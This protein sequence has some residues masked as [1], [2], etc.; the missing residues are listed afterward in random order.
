MRVN[1]HIR[2]SDTSWLC[3]P[4]ELRKRVQDSRL[5]RGSGYYFS[6]WFVTSL[7][8]FCYKPSGVLDKKTRN[9]QEGGISF[10]TDN[11]IGE[12]AAMV[13]YYFVLHAVPIVSIKRWAKEDGEKQIRKTSSPPQA[14][15]KGRRGNIRDTERPFRHK[16]AH[17]METHNDTVCQATRT[18]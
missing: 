11:T 7:A 15:E 13:R 2:A 17:E 12:H 16:N 3:G 1:A 14:L 6:P 10:V 9:R 8:P 4:K 5:R 18:P